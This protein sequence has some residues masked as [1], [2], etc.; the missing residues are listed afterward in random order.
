M[1]EGPMGNRTIT[2]RV[3]ESFYEKLCQLA[4]ENE[5][6]PTETAR[7]ILRENIKNAA[8]DANEKIIDA[9][10]IADD[11]DE[12]TVIAPVIGD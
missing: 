10:V 11:G 5:E 9:E 1:E 2:M 3:P 7:R 4:S 12:E 8:K 6:T